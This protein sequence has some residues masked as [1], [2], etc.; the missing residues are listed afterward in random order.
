[1]KLSILLLLC[2]SQVF[3]STQV[4]AANQSFDPGQVEADGEEVLENLEGETAFQPKTQISTI[5]YTGLAG[6]VLGLST[7]SFYSRPQDR[8]SNI[9]IGFGIGVILGAVWV[10]WAAARQPRQDYEYETNIEYE[11]EEA[12]LNW[13]PDSRLN[14]YALPITLSYSWAF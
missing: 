1:M 5:L 8:L 3:I 12:R 11:Y 6:G 4:L 13:S 10:T 2:F 7:L 14:G 9:A